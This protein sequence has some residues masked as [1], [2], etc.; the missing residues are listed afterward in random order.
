MTPGGREAGGGGEIMDD[1][2][3]LTVSLRGDGTQRVLRSRGPSPVVIKFFG[4][5][6]NRFRTVLRQFGS[7]FIVGKSSIRAAARR[8][9]ERSVLILWRKEGFDVP[10]LLDS[11][12]P[13]EN[14]N[15]CL[16][17]ENLR[18]P[19]LIAALCGNRMSL[20]D[21]CDFVARFA[22]VCG[23]RHARA[24]QLKEPRLFLEHPTFEHV[25]F[26]GDRMVHIDFE[27]VFTRT[28]GLEGLIGREITGFLRSLAKT[29]DEEFLPLLEA[30]VSAYPDRA[31][32]EAVRDDLLKYGTVPV[33]DW[34]RRVPFAGLVGRAFRGRK[35][36]IRQAI[37]KILD[38][39]LRAADDSP[40]SC[41]GNAGNIGRHPAL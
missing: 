33:L 31:R 41:R 40:G 8:E 1:F 23:K 25:L 28:T 3:V 9:M 27:I 10:E 35:G 15:L 5:K 34:M 6:R 18:G 30:F 14:A 22:D 12:L 20:E 39:V 37:A 24:L 13:E 21:K 11:R 19:S 4:L 29:T 16:A 7:L 38:K 32:L 36:E 2:E 26:D 17:M